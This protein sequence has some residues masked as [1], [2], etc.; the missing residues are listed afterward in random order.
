MWWGMPCI[1]SLLIFAEPM[2]M[3]RYT[4]MESADMTSPSTAR[5]NARESLVLPTAVG[6]A[7]TIMGGFMTRSS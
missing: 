6:P 1:C 2:S 7:R 3:C 4:C 5:A